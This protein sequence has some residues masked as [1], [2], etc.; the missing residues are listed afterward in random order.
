[1]IQIDGDPQLS[2]VLRLDSNIQSACSPD[3]VIKGCQLT[4]TP[5]ILLFLY[6][7]LLE[8]FLKFKKINF[9]KSKGRNIVTAP[10]IFCGHLFWIVGKASFIRSM[11]QSPFVF[12][13][14]R[15]E[16][17]CLEWLLC[18]VLLLESQGTHLQV[19]SRNG[20]WLKTALNQS[21]NQSI[22]I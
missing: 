15:K 2:R 8:I 22:C 18:G 11:R 7:F 17:S 20:L 1:M 12:N 6:H 5:S 4:G 16:A 19:N 21:I 9:I 13:Q 3:V 14:C 10:V